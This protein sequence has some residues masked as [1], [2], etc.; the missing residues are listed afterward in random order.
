MLA[1]FALMLGRIGESR[2]IGEMMMD[3]GQQF[4][5][6]ASALFAAGDMSGLKL[7]L[8]DDRRTNSASTTLFL[9]ITGL[10]SADDASQ[11]DHLNNQQRAVIQAM[12]DTQKGDVKAAVDLLQET[13]ADL[14]LEDRAYFFVGQDML[15]KLL[16]KQGELTDAIRVLERTTANPAGAALNNSGLFWM[17]CQRQLA[18]LYRAA[19]REYEAMRIEDQLRQLLVAADEYFPLASELRAT[20]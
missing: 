8:S 6:T 7:H 19:D 3:P 20:T 5:A 18:K 17:I 12:M 15:A 14:A 1:G 2:T 11:V 13:V 10:I 16:H 4:E 9:T